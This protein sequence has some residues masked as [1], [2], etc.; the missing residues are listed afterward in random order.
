MS[1]AEVL[2]STW[3]LRLRGLNRAQ[4]GRSPRCRERLLDYRLPMI[5]VDLLTWT[6]CEKP[7]FASTPRAYE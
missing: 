5:I 4:M 1:V 3:R 7:S 6:R 2:T